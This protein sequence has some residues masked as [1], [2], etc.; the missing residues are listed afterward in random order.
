MNW[1]ALQVRPKHDRLTAMLL[2]ENGYD[3]FAPVYRCLRKW[4]D[5][6]KEIEAPLLPG[7]VFCRFDPNAQSDCPVVAIPGVVKIVG[8]ANKPSP[9]D[10]TEMESVCLAAQSKAHPK[11]CPYLATGAKVIITRGPLAGIEGIL[12]R[13][14]K[15]DSLVVSI[16]MLQRS[17]AVELDKQFVEAS[18]IRIFG[19]SSQAGGE[20]RVP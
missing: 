17:I 12:A 15:K 19:E 4:S 3:I 14:N 20:L 5:R 10:A 6:I 13:I 18:D 8:F 7:Y 16:S 9:L 11:P 1:Y 2:K